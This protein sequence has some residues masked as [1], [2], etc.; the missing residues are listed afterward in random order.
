MKEGKIKWN[1]VV[2]NLNVETISDRGQEIVDVMERNKI[3]MLCVQKTCWKGQRWEMV[4]RCTTLVKTTK[5]I[6]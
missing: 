2:G 3:N 4:A 1:I 6:V 5:E